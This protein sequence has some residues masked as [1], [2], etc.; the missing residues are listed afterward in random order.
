MNRDQNTV[1]RVS[2]FSHAFFAILL[3]TTFLSIS[4]GV[5]VPFMESLPLYKG[6]FTR[7]DTELLEKLFPDARCTIFGKGG[8]SANKVLA[9]I[10]CEID[11]K[12]ETALKGTRS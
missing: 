12:Q 8:R 1:M 9:W 3:T 11:I 5:S 7:F 4:G 2:V 10:M 6:H